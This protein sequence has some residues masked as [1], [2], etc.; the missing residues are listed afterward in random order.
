[1]HGWPEIPENPQLLEA[2]LR[3][4]DKD[5]PAVID[6]R[7]GWHQLVVDCDLELAAID[8]NYKIYQIKEKFGTLRYYFQQSD[9]LTSDQNSYSP[10]RLQMNKIVSTYESVS[11]YN[12]ENCG[13]MGAQ[14]RRDLGR[15]QTLCDKC[16]DELTISLD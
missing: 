9:G 8:P 16:K 2:V 11:S 13:I 7:K 15:W 6:C 12:C 5:F 3:R 14:L 4:F 1:M 10:T